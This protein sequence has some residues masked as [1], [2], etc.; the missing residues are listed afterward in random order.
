MKRE[1]SQSSLWETAEIDYWKAAAEQ[2]RPEILA[3]IMAPPPPTIRQ[4][5]IAWYN[6]PRGT[7][8]II[9]AQGQA[10]SDTIRTLQ[11]R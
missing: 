11:G 7:A 4:R 2:I 3:E 5:L 10:M 1:D 9:Q 6:K 8:A